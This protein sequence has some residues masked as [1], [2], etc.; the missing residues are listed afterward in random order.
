M[1]EWIQHMA[2]A[3]TL[4]WDFFSVVHYFF[5]QNQVPDDFNPCKSA[6]LQD[7]WDL[8]VL[9]K[10]LLIASIKQGVTNCLLNYC[11][12]ALCHP[13]L[14]L[15]NFSFLPDIPQLLWTPCSTSAPFQCL[16]LFPMPMVT[17]PKVSPAPVLGSLWRHFAISALAP[18]NC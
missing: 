10:V 18:L 16:F 14:S 3:Q 12:L 6:C 9:N 11:C 15:P 8:W 13:R 2:A 1:F 7:R 5:V 17:P 4:I